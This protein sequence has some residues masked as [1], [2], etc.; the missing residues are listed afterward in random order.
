MG[1]MKLIDQSKV[2]DMSKISSID[3]FFELTQ[4]INSVQKAVANVMYGINHTLVGNAVPT[5]RDSYG[6]AFFT[7]PQLNLTQ[8]NLRNATKLYSFLTNKSSSAHRYV[9]M[10]LDPRLYYNE[11]LRCPFIDNNLAFIPILT[12]C[13]DNMSGWPDPVLPTWSSTE[14]VR[15]EQI[16]IADGYIDIYNTATIDCTFRNIKDESII[17]MF[18]LWIHYASYVFE[19]TLSPYMDMIAENEIDYNTRIY[20]LVLDETKTY[21]KKIAAI[22]AGFPVNV[23]MGKFFDFQKNENYNSQTKTFSIRFTF[24]GAEYDTDILALEFNKTGAIFNPGLRAMMNG[25][26]HNMEKV[27]PGLLSMFNY[28]CYPW[29]NLDTLELEWYVDKTSST[30]KSRLN[31]LEG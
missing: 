25:K 27:P 13:L 30:Y 19:G 31:Y 26:S 8:S 2:T 10:M 11:N 5:S 22:G 21:V 1:T 3:D 7:R 4:P 6:L 12:N 24:D 16:T 18:K 15:R 9:R 28:R 17:L 14:G 23:P 29:I 20:R